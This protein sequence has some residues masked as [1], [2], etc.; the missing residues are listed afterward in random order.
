MK[1][2]T[3]RHQG[4]ER[5]GAAVED[6]VVDIGRASSVGRHDGEFPSSILDLLAGGDD[7]LA[8]ANEC[9]LEVLAKGALNAA[10]FRERGVL[11][12][13]D[14]VRL[15]PPVPRPAK[16]ICLGRNYRAHAAEANMEVPKVPELFSKYLNTLI[17]HGDAIVIPPT[18]TQ[19]DYEAELAVVI[20]KRGR[21]IVEADAMSYVAGYTIFNDVSARDYQFRTSQWMAGKTFDTFGPMGPWITTRGDI[22]DP[23]ALGIRL[24]IGGEV[25]QDGTTAD[26]IFSVPAVIAYISTI[27]TLEPGDVISTGTPAGV[28]FVRKPPRFLQAGESVRITID[29]IGTLENPVANS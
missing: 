28:G 4:L 19:V 15:A 24:E 10:E 12:R 9:T 3:Y 6:H 29:G 18:T 13:L 16:I 25:L 14:E 21:H 5:V 23:H 2:V 20:G 11:F 7:L 27:V 26:L 1:L 8:R 22:P 17:G